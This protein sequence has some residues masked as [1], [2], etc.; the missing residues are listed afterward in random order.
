[1]THP[2]FTIG[3]STRS[4][5]EFTDLLRASEVEL[6]VDV[7]RFP[8]SRTNPQ[9]SADSLAAALGERSVD[10]RHAVDLGGRRKMA[11]VPPEVN[12][13]W[14]NRSFH[15]YADY[16]LSEEFTAAL[17]QLRDWGAERPLALMCSE[18]VWWR[19]HR[20]LIADHLLASGAD[21]RH[22]MSAGRVELARLT[23]GAVVGPEGRVT[24]PA[25]P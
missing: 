8:G 14:T 25:S 16:A 20:R 13:F 22:I 18:A 9:F 7:R 11:D 1:M 5:E 4:I 23:A 10:Y 6:L 21:V 2:F 24:Y 19:C 17:A 12:G 15:N 3:H